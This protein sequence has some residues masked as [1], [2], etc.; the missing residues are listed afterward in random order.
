MSS[1]PKPRR[2]RCFLALILALLGL[3]LACRFFWKATQGI[4]VLQP[5]RF[6][7]LFY[8]QLKHAHYNSPP[9]EEAFDVLIL[10]ASVFHEDFG[11]FEAIFER[12]LR[13]RTERPLSIYNLSTPAHT[14]R[15]S[16]LKYRYASEQRQFDLIIVY[17]NINELRANNCPPEFFRQDYSHYAFNR[18]ANAYFEHPSLTATSLGATAY[19]VFNKLAW[20]IG[21]LESIPRGRPNPKWLRSGSDIRTAACLQD[22]FETIIEDAQELGTPVLLMSYAYYIAGGYSISR[23][24]AKEL[25]YGE[26]EL[27]I[28]LWGTLENVR[29]GLEEHNRTIASLAA[30]YGCLWADQNASIPKNA[31]TFDDVCHL[32]CRGLEIFVGNL[33]QAIDHLF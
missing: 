15:D 23:F 5:E 22:N 20:K 8:P 13:K 14:S 1:V 21:L 11:D 27:P 3:E 24:R 18:L 25:D 7:Q 10:G 33:M 9:Q 32:T 6:V 28:E 31:E 30:E 12:E 2:Y 17:H 16:L 29:K 19:Y 4:P 26:S